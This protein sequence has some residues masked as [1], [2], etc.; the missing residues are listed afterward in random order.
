MCS[1]LA[2]S[3]PYRASEWYLDGYLTAGSNPYGANVDRI[4]TEYMGAGVRIGLID[5]GFDISH[6]DLAGRFDLASSYDPHD[7]GTVNIMPDSTSDVHGTWVAGVVGARGDNNYGTIGVA[8][9]ATLVGYYM[10]TGLGG[11]SRAEI[12]DLLA[13]QVNV[14]ISNNSWGYT[15][16]FSDNFRDVNWAVMQD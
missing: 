9:E 15:S 7:T 13:R 1:Q 5:Q 8:P 6:P 4:S 11:S 14:D 3:N 10:R 2:A 16:A 12:S